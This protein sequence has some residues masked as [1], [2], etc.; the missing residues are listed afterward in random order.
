MRLFNRLI[1]FFI[2]HKDKELPPLFHIGGFTLD[3]EL[4][5]QRCKRVALDCKAA[6]IGPV[7]IQKRG[8]SL[9]SA[10]EKGEITFDM[11]L[12]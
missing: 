8:S 2:G 6:N 3:A 5:C 10:I 7:L 12:R 11:H 9:K 4:W 1:C